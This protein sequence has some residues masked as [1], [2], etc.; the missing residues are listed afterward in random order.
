MDQFDETDLLFRLHEDPKPKQVPKLSYLDYSKFIY[1]GTSHNDQHIYYFPRKWDD[2]NENGI[3]RPWYIPPFGPLAE[4]W[5]SW[6][7]K[8]WPIHIQTD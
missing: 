3:Q 1:S 4:A 2:K 5:L 6:K 8:R 7:T